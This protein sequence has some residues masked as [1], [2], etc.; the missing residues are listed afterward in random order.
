MREA[1]SALTDSGARSALPML[2]GF[3]ADIEAEAENFEEASARVDEALSLAQ[4]TGERWMDSFLHRI[5]GEILLKRDPTN[6]S[7]VEEAFLTAVAIAQQQ[8]AKSFELQATLSLA[9]LYQSTGRPAA[10][11]A[12]LA[13]ALEGLRPTPEFPEIEQAQ[14]LLDAARCRRGV[15]GEGR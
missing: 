1:L 4:Q 8:K 3:I 14:R 12:V 5:R 10:A 15:K 2:L 13:P 6:P 11:Q 7:P 9:K